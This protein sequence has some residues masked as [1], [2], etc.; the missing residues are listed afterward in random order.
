MSQG[1]GIEWTD[2]TWN[3]VVGCTRASAGCDNCY[4]VTM[5][6]RLETMGQEKY[7]GLTVLNGRGGR[8]FNGTV[9]TVPEALEVPLRWKKPRRVFVNSMSDL[10]HKSVPQSFIHEVFHIIKRCPQHTFQVLTKRP[11][12]AAAI[13]WECSKYGEDYRYLPNL[14]LGTS[15]EDQAAADARIG[16]LLRCPAAVR[17]LSCEPLIGGID[18]RL[19]KAWS[20]GQVPAHAPVGRGA[21]DIDW[22]IVGGESGAGARACNVGWLRSIIVQCK[23]AGVA[24][25]VKQVGGKP[26]EDA[27]AANIIRSWGDATIRI[28][29]EF[30]QIHLVNKKGGDPSEWPEDLRVR[31]MP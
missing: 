16:H 9:R 20:D 11:E 12:I 5:T 7:A 17:F 27:D 6:H 23:S 10:F 26:Y 30:V 22:V 14:W 18:L 21:G 4:A 1:S 15:C 3:P 31:E 28:N 8:H 25:F 24:C 29:G 19:R 13:E 2:A